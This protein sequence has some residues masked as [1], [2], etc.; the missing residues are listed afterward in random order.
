MAYGAEEGLRLVDDLVRDG[1]L[2]NYALLYAARADLVLK[3]GRDQEALADLRRAHELTENQ[4]E[5]MLLAERILLLKDGR[6]SA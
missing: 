2:E 4:A 3:L 6:G 1:S 5:R